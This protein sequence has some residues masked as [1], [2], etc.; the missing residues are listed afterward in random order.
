MSKT[1]KKQNE[2]IDLDVQ[3][4]SGLL[5]WCKYINYKNPISEHAVKILENELQSSKAT[6][7]NDYWSWNIGI[8][9]VGYTGTYFNAT[10]ANYLDNRFLMWANNIENSKKIF[11]SL[12]ILKKYLLQ[13]EEDDK[14]DA[15]HSYNNL[16]EKFRLNSLKI[17]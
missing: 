2:F 6:N 13:S 12:R 4:E 10:L 5:N 8:E 9:L 17:L 11:E 7:K 1:I 14:K 16:I 15:I 3:T